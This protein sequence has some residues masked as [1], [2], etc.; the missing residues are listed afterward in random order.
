MLGDVL[1]RVGCSLGG[2]V[3]GEGSFIITRQLPAFA[4]GDPRLR[5]V[6]A[7]ATAQCDRPMLEA[8]Q[9]FLGAGSVRDSPRRRPGWQ[10][11]STFAINSR[12]KVR[13]VVIP[14]ADRFL[15]AS[16]KRRQ[17]DQWKQA[18]D[19]YEQAHPSR[20]GLGPAR[21]S[22]TGCDK[23]VRARGLCRSHYYQATGH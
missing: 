13:A 8:L 1:W 6:F 17:Y 16:A 7:V 15:P 4:N 12:L 3:A 11:V 21:R 14:F 18:F 22:V 10:P 9:T 2:F 23:P 19:A 5:F 20:W